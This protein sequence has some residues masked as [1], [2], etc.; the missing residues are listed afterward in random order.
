MKRTN[1]LPLSRVVRESSEIQRFERIF[2][3]HSKCL[4]KELLPLS[5]F[6]HKAKMFLQ[7]AEKPRYE[8]SDTVLAVLVSSG[9]LC[10]KVAQEQQET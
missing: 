7:C 8:L 4:G 9:F 10:S 1:S 6:I 5:N 3:L 2:G